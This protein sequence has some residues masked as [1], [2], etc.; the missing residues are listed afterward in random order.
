MAPKGSGSGAA[1]KPKSQDMKKKAE[2]K[3]KAKDEAA[4]IGL[5]ME[6]KPLVA[7][8]KDEKEEAM[9]EYEEAKRDE[10]RL[11]AIKLADTLNPVVSIEVAFYV[12][13]KSSGVAVNPWGEAK[14]RKK[15]AEAQLLQVENNGQGKLLRDA[16]MTTLA[17]VDKCQ[18]TETS[19][20]VPN[21]EGANGAGGFPP[22]GERAAKC[23]IRWRSQ[24]QKGLVVAAVKVCQKAEAE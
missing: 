4:A 23:H 15:F 7:M 3:Q 17:K 2:A 9:S 6:P 5:A 13:F 8:S 14:K 24:Y 12:H 16:I 10:K 19:P 18:V 1:K 22:K 21:A 20:A 11:A